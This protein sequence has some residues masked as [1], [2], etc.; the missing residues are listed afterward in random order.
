VQETDQAVPSPVGHLF[1]V[2]DARAAGAR[3]LRRFRVAQT[4]EFTEKP[5]LW[6]SG[7]VKRPEGRLKAALLRKS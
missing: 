4:R 6:K 7:T 2:F 1:S 5:R 3:R